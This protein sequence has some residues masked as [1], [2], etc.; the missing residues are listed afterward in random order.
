M[1]GIDT[2]KI[3]GY[4]NMT[5][6]EK[7]KALESYTFEVPDYSGYVKKDVFDK[8]ASELAQTKK[9]LKARMSEEEIK[10]NETEALLARYKEEAETLKK[11]KEISENKA[12]LISIGYDDKLA[13]ETAKAMVEGDIATVMK[14]QMTLIESVKK[15]AV[16]EAMAST[17]PPVGKP[18]DG[19][20]TVSKEQFSKMSYAEMAELFRTNPELYE[21]LT[22]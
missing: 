19:N 13:G 2:T 14:N 21:S 11:E 3:E 17:V 5:A 16:G 12:Q 18:T 22:K 8:T 9:D 6:E 4:E 20:K 1:A 10:K 15:A 7:I